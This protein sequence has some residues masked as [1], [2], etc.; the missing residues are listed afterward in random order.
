MSKRARTANKKKF[1]KRKRK[2]NK[3]KPKS[4]FKKR[5]QQIVDENLETKLTVYE[6]ENA[7]TQAGGT[8]QLYHNHLGTLDTNIIYT[9]QGIDTPLT[10]QLQNRIG[11]VIHSEGISYQFVLEL[12][13]TQ[14]ECHFKI[15]VVKSARGDI[16]PSGREELYTLRKVGYDPENGKLRNRRR[17]LP[18]RTRRWTSRP[19]YRQHPLRADDHRKIVRMRV[20]GTNVRAQRKHHTRP[21]VASPP[22]QVL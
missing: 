14:I 5:V 16:F 20:P 15:F 8:V 12:D 4:T 21:R 7:F 1:V 3:R 19:Y 10:S 9:S 2:F 17:D 6:V 13:V 18:P 11:D 22:R